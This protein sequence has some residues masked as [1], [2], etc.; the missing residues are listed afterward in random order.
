[1]ACSSDGRITARLPVSLVSSS[2]PIVDRITGPDLSSMHAAGDTSDPPS[3]SST[4]PSVTASRTTSAS[5]SGTETITSRPTASGS[6]RNNDD[7]NSSSETSTDDSDSSPSPTDD[8]ATPTD[9]EDSSSTEFDPRLPPGG[10]QMVTPAPLSGNQYY[11]IGDYVT[12]GWNYTSLSVTPSAIDIMASCS[13][14]NNLYTIAVNQSVQSSQAVVWDTG[15]E[16]TASAP[17]PMSVTSPSVYRPGAL[18][19]FI[20]QSNP[21]QL[22]PT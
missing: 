5:G 6:S 14:N 2:C 8:E 22:Q 16:A 10:V 12:F 7:D 15:A 18:L 19:L 21:S 3:P 11:K 20:T 17:L 13:L 4:A 9:S 1:M